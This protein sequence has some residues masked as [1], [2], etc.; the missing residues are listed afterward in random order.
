MVPT[1]GGAHGT[2]RAARANLADAPAPA[3]TATRARSAGQRWSKEL[4]RG[5]A[6]LLPDYLLQ[7]CKAKF[8]SLRYYIDGADELPLI[9]QAEQDSS[10][11][12]DV[13]P[14]PGV[15]RY[16]NGVGPL[17]R[18]SPAHLGSTSTKWDQAHF[19]GAGTGPLPWLQSL[20]Q[21]RGASKSRTDRAALAR[22]NPHTTTTPNE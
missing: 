4:D 2:S 18:L 16:G 8:G 13:C 14:A 19:L 21:C 1:G 20:Y 15:T 5:I 3:G 11:I 17:A 9:T 12:C 7:Q 10:T 6:A 22:P